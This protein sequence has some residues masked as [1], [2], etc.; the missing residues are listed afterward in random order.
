MR[1]LLRWLRRIGLTALALALVGLGAA[2]ITAHTGWG[3]EQLRARVEA[4]LRDAFPGGARVASLDGSVLGTLTLQGVELDGPDHRP[5]VT[6]GALRVAIALWPLAFQTARLDRAVADDV[7]VFVRD[8]PAAPVAAPPGEPSAWQVEIPALEVHRAVVEIERVELALGDLDLAA[9]VTVAR[10]RVEVSGAVHGWWRRAGRPAAM[11]TAGGSAVLDG[12]T[13]IPGAI[14]VIDGA[15]V[16]ASALV[17]DVDHPGG[18]ITIAAPAAVIAAQVPELAALGWAVPGDVAAAIRL[19]PDGAATRLAVTAAAG[20]ARLWAALRGE[21]ARRTARGLISA[22]SI[23]LGAATLGRVRG[24]G[25]L[26]A[27][28][29]AGPGRARGALIGHGE[30]AVDGLPVRRAG[31]VIAGSLDGATALAIGGGDDAL[32]LAAAVRG[33]RQ[34]GGPVH[35]RRLLPGVVRVV[36]VAAR[37]VGD[38][39]LLAVGLVLSACHRCPPLDE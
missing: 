27:A 21:P 6:V 38:H 11:L 12:G 9:A 18:A 14:A 13:R 24:R 2:L 25:N 10:G 37:S 22:T 29:D 28:V 26:L 23:D 32:R 4:A 16:V 39:R 1:S 33:H 36:R 19:V 8:R 20:D 35:R 31:V 17:F 15:T 7:R 34:A 5:L 30:L 3:R